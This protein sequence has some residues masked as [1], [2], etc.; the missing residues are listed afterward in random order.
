MTGGSFPRSFLI[1]GTDTSLRV[2]GEVRLSIDYFLSGGGQNANAI[3]TNTLGSGGILETTPLST[4]GKR[5]P[6]PALV[7][8]DF[9]R[10]RSRF[11]TFV[12][13]E[14]RIHFETRTPTAW[15]EATT[16]L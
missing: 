13:R 12:P 16:I 7:P 5:F 11:I 6:G 1:P 9:N 8:L 3:P 10:S 4:G 15:G 2:G 14:S